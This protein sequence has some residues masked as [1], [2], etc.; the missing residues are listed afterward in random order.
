MIKKIIYVV[1][2]AAVLGVGYWLVSPLFINR[3]VSEKLEEFVPMPTEMTVVARGDFEGVSFH[4]AR[5]SAKIVKSGDKYFVSF[6]EN[7]YVTNGPDLLVY[8]GKDGVYD[9]KAEL[10]NLKGNIGSQV[11]EIPETINL[12]DYNEVW[13]WCRA[14]RVGFG[15]AI[16]SL[17]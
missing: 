2:A 7:F 13:V 6:E 11:Y 1:I 8:L 5:G 3:E 16:L 12:N 9:P 17:E 14:F 15:K 10:G 4:E